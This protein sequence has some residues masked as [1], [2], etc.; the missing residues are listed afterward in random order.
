MMALSL[1][2]T[3]CHF[4]IYLTPL[5]KNRYILKLYNQYQRVEAVEKARL[6]HRMYVL[7][8]GFEP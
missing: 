1:Q 8:N 4:L 7:Y 3:K 6:D 5:P 2:K